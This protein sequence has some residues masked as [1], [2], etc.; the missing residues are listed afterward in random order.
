MRYFPA[1]LNLAGRPCLVVGGGETAARKVRLLRKAD[2]QVRLVAPDV[3]EELRGLADDG[4][5]TWLRRPFAA[6]DLA[7]V[8]LVIAA[9]DIEAL[10]VTVSKAAQAAGVPVNVV[11]RP[12]LSS[13]TVPAIVDRDP[14]VVGIS[15]GGTAP[16]LARKVRAGIE[17][18][19]P[20][21]L[22]RLARFAER[23]RFAVQAQMPEAGARRRFWERFFDSP[24]AARVLEGDETGASD[25]M[26]AWVN[27]AARPAECG[28]VHIVGA[29]PGDPDL[30]TLKALRL[31]QQADVILYDRLVGPDI[32]DYARRD[33]ERIDVGKRKGRHALPQARIN[34]LLA[35]RAGRGERVVR[36]KGGDPLV[37]G[38][39]GEEQAYLQAR[40]IAVE[41]VPGITAALGCAAAAG[42]PLTQR[43]LAQS[44][45]FATGHG[46]QADGTAGEPDLDWAGLAQGGQTLVVYMGVSTAGAIARRL[47]EHGAS[48]SLPLAVIEKGTRSDQKVVRGRLENLEGLIASAG[49]TGPALLVIGEVA[50][51]AASAP[52]AAAALAS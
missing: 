12:A 49:I 52:I 25:R 43:G 9:S 51:E 4:S 21:R 35:E 6:S 8:A 30:L 47:I 23:F 27:G 11:D 19:L 36:L 2:A 3:T 37:F 44:V 46:A 40:G 38:R 15:S 33:A 10:D 18:L 29:G 39:G 17:A 41:I 31:I 5:L 32:L 48:P 13:F 7:G 20:A 16:V 14:F 34:A 50:R 28:V 45:T 26:L 24:V 22:G 1:F 42:I